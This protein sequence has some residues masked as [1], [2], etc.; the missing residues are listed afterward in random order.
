MIIQ[1][2]T[3][4]K[5][6]DFLIEAFEEQNV[7]IVKEKLDVGDY[8]NLDHKDWEHQ[9]IVDRKKDVLELCR[10][11]GSDFDRFKREWL[12]A[13]EHGILLVILIEDNNFTSME[14]L[15]RW[16]NPFRHKNA[17]AITGDRLYRTVNTISQRYA[18][19]IRFEFCHRDRFAERIIELLS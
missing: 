9:V 6:N 5:K 1:V 2:D 4:E 11:I 8:A 14:D 19:C 10:C 7:S 15:Q 13:R 12:R 17:H 16:I 3:R 18:D